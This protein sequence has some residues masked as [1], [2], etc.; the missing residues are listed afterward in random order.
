VQNVKQGHRLKTD[1]VVWLTSQELDILFGT[2]NARNLYSSGSMKTIVREL[3]KYN[4]TCE[5][6]HSCKLATCCR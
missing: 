3:V 2:W 5:V 1:S 4:K 6:G